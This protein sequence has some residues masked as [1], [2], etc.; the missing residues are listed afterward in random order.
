MVLIRWAI[1]VIHAGPSLNNKRFLANDDGPGPFDHDPWR[2]RGPLDHYRR[3]RPFHYYPGRIHH[4]GRR[5][6]ITRRR[7]FYPEAEINAS[8]TGIR[9]NA[10]DS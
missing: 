7:S 1:I 4:F 10:K 3:R 6:S 5:H 2:G 8:G 9:R